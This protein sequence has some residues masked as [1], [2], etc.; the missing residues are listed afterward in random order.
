M[1]RPVD[2]NDEQ[3]NNKLMQ[4]GVKGILTSPCVNQCIAGCISNVLFHNFFISDLENLARHVRQLTW[5][6]VL[7]TL[8]HP[9][10]SSSSLQSEI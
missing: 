10:T 2:K 1:S 7:C 9:S 4:S 3:S 5:P 8:V 6:C